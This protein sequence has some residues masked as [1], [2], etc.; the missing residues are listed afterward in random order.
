MENSPTLWQVETQGQIYEA[1]FEELKQW[2]SEG[3]VLPL[4]KVKRGDLRWLPVEKV[5]ELNVFLKSNDFNDS[6]SEA[7][8]ANDFAE[9]READQNQTAPEDSTGE[10]A[11]EINGEKV[12]FRHPDA[13]AVY[14]CAICKKLFCKLCPN[15][16]GGSV[17][18]CPFCGS[19]CQS[20]DEALGARRPIGAISKPYL[21]MDESLNKSKAEN[22]I[23]GFPKKHSNWLQYVK[24][25]I[26]KA[27]SFIFLRP[28][29]RRR[30]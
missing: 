15:S 27:I 14:A 2:I 4:D 6:S 21:K 19:L 26:S 25:S 23:A 3:A 5:P 30:R 8:A 7:P 10:P 28:F 17:K 1:D 12:C 29:K 11:W 18:L 16:Y 22:R 13:E 20:A 9:N 24:N